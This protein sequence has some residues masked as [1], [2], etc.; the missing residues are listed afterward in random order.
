MYIFSVTTISVLNVTAFLK[1]YFSYVFIYKI[2]LKLSHLNFSRLCT[3]TQA[4][5]YRLANCQPRIPEYVYHHRLYMVLSLKGKQTLFAE[6]LF[7]SINNSFHIIGDDIPR[8][9]ICS[10]TQT[11]TKFHQSLRFETLRDWERNF[12]LFS[13]ISTLVSYDKTLCS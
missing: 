8:K 13:Y 3:F 2:T 1:S 6:T 5:P 10:T 12:H 4:R 9:L 7:E 11:C